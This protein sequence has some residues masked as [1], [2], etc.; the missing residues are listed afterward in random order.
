MGDQEGRVQKWL[1]LFCCNTPLLL[2]TLFIDE[3]AAGSPYKVARGKRDIQRGGV[4][5][6][7]EGGDLKRWASKVK[8]DKI[9]G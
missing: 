6:D 2:V 5:E 7:C 3:G 9:R 1:C 4:F 8:T